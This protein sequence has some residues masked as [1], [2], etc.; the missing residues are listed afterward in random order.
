[1][2]MSTRPD[3]T[4]VYLMVSAAHYNRYTLHNGIRSAKSAVLTKWG[5]REFVGPA[6]IFRLVYND[7]VLE[8]DL[9]KTPRP[10]GGV[11]LNWEDY[12]VQPLPTHAEILEEWMAVTADEGCASRSGLGSICVLD[13]TYPHTRH[14]DLYSSWEY[15]T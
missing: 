2:G 3:P 1:M 4:K 11:T 5:S 7:W 9:P 12:R 15:E 14:R 13:K 8:Y 10:R 6:Q